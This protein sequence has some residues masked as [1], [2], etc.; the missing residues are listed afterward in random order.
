M[1]TLAPAAASFGASIRRPRS[2]CFSAEYNDHKL[3]ARTF[4]AN[5]YFA[6]IFGGEN[7]KTDIK[8]A[9]LFINFLVSDLVIQKNE[10]MFRQTSDQRL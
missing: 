8:V 9:D 7:T 2:G 3:N 5:H 1:F 4:P 10:F 6:N